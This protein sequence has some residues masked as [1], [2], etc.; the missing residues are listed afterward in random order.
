M[1]AFVWMHETVSCV[2]KHLS[3][4]LARSLLAMA[5]D[6]RKC[7]AAAV[8]V[9]CDFSGRHLVSAPSRIEI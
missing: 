1:A 4:V 7:S 8:G 3:L 5:D 2:I 9:S 6:E